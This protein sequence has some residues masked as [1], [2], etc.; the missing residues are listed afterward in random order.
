M[1]GA[2]IDRSDTRC[3]QT[4]NQKCPQ[5]VKVLIY[6]VKYLNIYTRL[7]LNLTDAWFPEDVSELLWL[8]FVVLYVSNTSFHDSILSYDSQ[9]QF[10]FSANH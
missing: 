10:V 9:L 8:N 7:A 1:G 3:A 2:T 6:P 4:M 5:Q